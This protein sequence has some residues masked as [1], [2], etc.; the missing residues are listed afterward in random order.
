MTKGWRNAACVADDRLNNNGS[1]LVRMCLKRSLNGDDV[2]TM[3]LRPVAAR[4]SRIADIVASVPELTKR[5]FSM[6]G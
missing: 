4:A 3:I 6:A 1:D 2:V 5:I